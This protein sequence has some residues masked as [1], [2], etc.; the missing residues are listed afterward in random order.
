MTHDESHPPLREGVLIAAFGS[1]EPLAHRLLGG[2]EAKVRAAFPGASVRWAFTSGIIRERLAGEGKKT[3]S[4]RKALD[5]FRF[6]RFQRV[7]VQSLHVIPGKEYEDLR[8]AVEERAATGAMRVALGAPL[9]AAP[10][11]VERAADAVAGHLPTERL[12]NE[13][14]LLMGHGAWH[15]GD[16][17]Y[18]SLASA[19]RAR[20]PLLVLRTLDGSAP[21]EPVLEEL[22]AAGVETVWLTPLLAVVGAHVQHDMVGAHAGSWQS[23]IEAAGLRCAPVMR[24]ALQNPALA[25]IWITHLHAAMSALRSS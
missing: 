22:R 8:A 13:A 20:D 10:A 16:S 12:P 18:A 7:A 25:D 24:S 1:S 14:V 9:L 11:D 4:V 3:D 5:R 6:E 19:L 21:L 17:V 15:P 2:F 23:R